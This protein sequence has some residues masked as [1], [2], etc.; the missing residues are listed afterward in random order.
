MFALSRKLALYVEDVISL[1]A[2]NSILHR[3][4]PGKKAETIEEKTEIIAYGINYLLGTVLKLLL[5]FA[6]SILLGISR[7]TIIMVAVFMSFRSVAGGQH[8]DTY[9]K[10]LVMSVLLF[11]LFGLAAQY[12]EWDI[13]SR[14]II[15]ILTVA[16]SLYTAIRFV[17][18]THPNHNIRMKKQKKL[19]KIS[20]VYIAV[21]A[22]VMLFIKSNLYVVA[23]SFGLFLVCFSI[24]PLGY[25][26]FGKISEGLKW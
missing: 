10:C 12:I 3:V 6:I 24:V 18:R 26:L 5:I 11:L 22:V 4:R 21:Y 17:P 19:K 1:E 9:I 25:K 14:N 8:M 23:A 20:F 7:P 13:V 16:F 2:A 15:F